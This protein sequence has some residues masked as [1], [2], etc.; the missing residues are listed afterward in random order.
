MH[1]GEAAHRP[2]PKMRSASPAISEV[3]F[4]S[5]SCPRRVHTAA[6]R[7]LGRSAAGSP[8]SLVDQHVGVDR[9]AER[10]RDGGD[11][12]QVSVACSRQAR[13]AGAG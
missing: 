7:G 5:R 12:G 9:H 10:E 4:E 11:A 13:S 8:Y 2:W 1:H 3:T 6:D